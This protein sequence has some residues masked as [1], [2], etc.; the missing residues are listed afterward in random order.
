MAKQLAATSA[1]S[2]TTTGR[3]QPVD[4]SA[5]SSFVL[6]PF[7]EDEGD[8]ATEARTARRAPTIIAEM[9]TKG[10]LAAVAEAVMQMDLAHAPCWCSATSGRRHQRRLPARG[11]QHRLDRP[12]AQ[13]PPGSAAGG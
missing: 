12:A 7:D 9:E 13:E 3:A 6:A 5:A 8:D 2:R 4:T 10:A 1:G 11:R